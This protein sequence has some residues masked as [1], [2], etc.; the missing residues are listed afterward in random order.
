MV[1]RPDHAGIS[2][3]DVDNRDGARQAARHLVDIGAHRIGIVGAPSNTTAG[4]DRLTG[5]VQGLGECDRT[6]D[7]DLR[8]DGDF[9]EGGGY[10]AMSTLLERGI[11]A[12]FVASDT[13]SMGALRAARDRGVD[14]PGDVALVGFDG[15]DGFGSPGNGAPALTTIRQPVAETASRAVEMLLGL[16]S[17]ELSGPTSDVLPVELLVR[18]TSV[19]RGPESRGPDEPVGVLPSNSAEDSNL[20]SKGEGT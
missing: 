18:G 10:D 19:R 6:L 13:M 11:D 9:T 2:F 3:V 4:D 5:F 16:I 15:F 8:V 20:N 12:V 14:V 1:G 17:G 7:D